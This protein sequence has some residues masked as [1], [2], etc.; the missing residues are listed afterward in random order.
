MNI[1]HQGVL[2]E[3]PL[4]NWQ[5][6][7]Y[8]AE[9]E[10]YIYEKDGVVL[11]LN[12][13]TYTRE[14]GTESTDDIAKDAVVTLAQNRAIEVYPEHDLWISYYV[15][16]SV[17]PVIDYWHLA[18]LYDDNKL[19]VV[20]VISLFSTA[21]S[22]DEIK[23]SFKEAKVLKYAQKSTSEMQERG[24]LGSWNH[25]YHEQ[26]D[27]E[28]VMTINARSQFEHDNIEQLHVSI[29]LLEN[30]ESLAQATLVLQ[31]HWEIS[32]N[33]VIQKLQACHQKMVQEP[34]DPFS[35]KLFHMM[36]DRMTCVGTETEMR[37]VAIESN[38]I[39][40]EGM[41]GRVVYKKKEIKQ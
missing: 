17:D 23:A 26:I 20:S 31:N 21:E 7:A 35:A 33:R 16:E 3:L 41:L 2:L 13:H 22:F 24:F 9:E 4:E 32:D 29:T 15:G 27:E 14:E 5:Y 25:E 1:T 8:D 34:S 40:V 39:V 10:I 19:L 11:N 6:S 30:D 12:V 37:I 28:Q 18:T 38:V 36:V